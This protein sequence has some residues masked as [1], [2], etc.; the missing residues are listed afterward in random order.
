MRKRKPKV[1][2]IA[3]DPRYG[4]AMVTQFVN[5]LMFSGKK[6]TSFRI[7]YDAMDI[8]KEKVA[9]EEIDEFE[10]WK[11]ALNNA[12]PQVEASVPVREWRKNCLL[13]SSQQAATK[14]SP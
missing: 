14:A 2:V 5:M 8:I 6:S 4:D 3:P 13:N 1:R 10:V 12:M 9:S 11:R 7:F